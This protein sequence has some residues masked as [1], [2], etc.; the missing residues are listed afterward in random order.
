LEA[1]LDTAMGGTVEVRSRPR[2]GTRVTVRL[3]RRWA[4]GD[5][6]ESTRTMAI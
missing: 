2:Q 6:D 4:T 3:P 5:R 1:H